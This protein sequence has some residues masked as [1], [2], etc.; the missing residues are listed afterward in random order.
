MLGVLLAAGSP[1]ASGDGFNPFE[2]VPGATFWTWVIFLGSLWPIWKFVFGPITKA[3]AERDAKVE[4]AIL[5]A[6]QARH[7]AE[8]QVAAAKMELE[9]ARADAKRMVDDA[10]ARAERQAQDALA[11]AKDEADRQLRKAR[12]EIAAEKNKALAEIR[13]EVVDL[14]IQSTGRLLRREVNDDAHKKVVA[15]FLKSLPN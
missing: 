5:A 15:D 14:T 10:T 11:K 4:N 12:D 6:D 13:K 3:L 2:F 8:E 1:L 7:K 9:R